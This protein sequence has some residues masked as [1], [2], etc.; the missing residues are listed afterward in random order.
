MN[1]E[2]RHFDTTLLRFSATE[3][4]N[5]PEM[6]ILSLDEIVLRLQT[7]KLFEILKNCGYI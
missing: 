2:L 3:D 1:F 7:A 6:K 4:S 5:T